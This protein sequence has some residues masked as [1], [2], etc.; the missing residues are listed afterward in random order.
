[1]TF[2]FVDSSLGYLGGSED[3]YTQHIG[4][5]VDLWDTASP[6]YG[7][8]GT[9]SAF[10]YTKRSVHIIEEH[11]ATYQGQG[12]FMYIA[13]AVTH[14]PEQAPDRFV[15]LYPAEWVLGRRQYNGMA[16]AMDESVLNITA[17]L[18]RTGLWRSSLFVYS[19]DN[20]GPSLVGGPS[21]ANNFPVPV[22]NS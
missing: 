1:M 13:L 16:S 18:R 15:D 21:F 12:L 11:A 7:Q 20:G 14:E 9:Y 19:S 8:N 3:H 10:L 6:A 22:A 2:P 17:A 5:G 4:A